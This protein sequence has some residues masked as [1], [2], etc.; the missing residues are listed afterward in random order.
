MCPRVSVV[1][2]LYQKGETIGRCLRSIIA[3]TVPAA[4]V[5]VVDDGST[6]G[7]ALVAT[8]CG[9]SRV[10]IVRQANAGPGAARNRGIAEA[11]G[12]YVAFLDADD[13]WDPQYLARLLAALEAQPT[14]VAAA[15]A[16]R[17]AR[18]SL[19]PRWRRLGLADGVFAATAR[20]PPECVVA[21]IAFLSPC[22]TLIRRKTL[23]LLSG[24]YERDGCRYG[25][26]AF[27]AIQLV[28]NG[29]IIVVLEDLVAVDAGASSLNVRRRTRPLEP[30]FAGAPQ[31]RETT[32]AH[33]R[34][35]L[36]DVLAIRAGKAACVMA[37]W[38]RFREARELLARHTRPRDLRRTWVLL[39]RLVTALGVLSPR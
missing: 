34:P 37:W 13:A 30:L 2:P 11:S 12:E 9:D 31:L 20:T 22:T 5:I 6:D 39:G 4:E 14:A 10:R 27:L 36:D 18:G 7:G 28:M 23:L 17:T 21:L 16:F 8:A 24:F 1:V 29:P 32:P 19:V 25:E 26:D 35:L 3:Q 38:G 33:L 15:C